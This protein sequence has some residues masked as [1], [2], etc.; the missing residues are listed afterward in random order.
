MTCATCKY[1]SEMVAGT[2]KSFGIEA[3]CLCPLS[4]NHGEYTVESN[5]CAKQEAGMAVDDPLQY[6]PGHCM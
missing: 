1:W 4:D 3:L 5:S 6:E 2:N